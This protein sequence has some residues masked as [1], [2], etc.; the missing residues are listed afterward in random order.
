MGNPKYCKP[1]HKILRYYLFKQ[2]VITM[3]KYL[4]LHYLEYSRQNNAVSTSDE[5]AKHKSSKKQVYFA[6]R[7]NGYNYNTYICICPQEVPYTSG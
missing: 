5:F 2:S 1:D 6:H 7:V 4:S 3:S